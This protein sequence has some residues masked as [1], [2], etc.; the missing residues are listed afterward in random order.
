[1]TQHVTSTLDMYLDIHKALS[2][3]ANIAIDQLKSHLINPEWADRKLSA[4][5]GGKFPMF[6]LSERY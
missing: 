5:I 6:N 4:R 1:M 2:L 3:A